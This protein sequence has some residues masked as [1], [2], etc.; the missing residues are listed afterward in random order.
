MTA[1]VSRLS[2]RVPGLFTA[3]VTATAT[4]HVD[5]V[6]LILP[7]KYCVVGGRRCSFQTHRLSRYQSIFISYCDVYNVYVPP[8][9]DTCYCLSI[10]I[11]GFSYESAV[12]VAAAARHA[13]MRRARRPVVALTSSTLQLVYWPNH[14]EKRNKANKTRKCGNYSDVLPLKAAR[15]HSIS[16]LT[17]FGASNLSC[18]R[19]Q[20]RF[21]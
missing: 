7:R 5:D 19:T 6:I 20:C 10:H 21:I 13:R 4:H 16:N 1:D 2:M 15:R 14:G 9:R 12:V 11:S 17:S 8:P 18:R 3:D